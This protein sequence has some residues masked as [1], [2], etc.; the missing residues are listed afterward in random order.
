MLTTAISYWGDILL[1]LYQ[2]CVSN[3]IT[4]TIIVVVIFNLSIMAIGKLRK[5]KE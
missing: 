1:Q 5:L 4:S 2:L 3:I